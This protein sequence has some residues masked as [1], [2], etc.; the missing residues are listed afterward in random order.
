MTTAQYE[1][2]LVRISAIEE[3]LNNLTTAINRCVTMNEVSQLQI[4][5]ETRLADV[6]VTTAALASRVQAIE[7]EPLV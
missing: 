2:L 6:E 3:H 1:A 7:E 4:L 5:T